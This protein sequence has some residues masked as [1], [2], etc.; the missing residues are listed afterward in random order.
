MHT[1][2]PHPSAE[3]LDK[4]V[5]RSCR[6]P[7]PQRLLA[8]LSAVV[9]V[10]A[11]GFAAS[12]LVAPSLG[13]PTVGTASTAVPI[14]PARPGGQVAFASNRSGNYEIY[15]TN[16]AGTQ[17]SPNLTHHP[18]YD[19]KPAISPDGRRSPSRATA[20]ATARSTS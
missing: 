11:A 1:Q 5:P 19:S 6:V 20:M 18:A 13:A 7:R 3:P 9:V 10:A 2:R 4:P 14:L 17:V 8:L 16:A 15:T 12:G